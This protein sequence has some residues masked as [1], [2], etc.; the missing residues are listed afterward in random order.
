V[1]PDGE[2][3]S[4]GCQ[5]LEG[6]PLLPPGRLPACIPS[7]LELRPLLGNGTRSECSKT[8]ALGVLP[9][10]LFLARY[11]TVTIRPLISSPSRAEFAGSTL[12]EDSVL[13]SLR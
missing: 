7:V 8:R 3:Q 5:H 4:L 11:S 1:E 2:A 12:V 6:S 13:V 9:R 10:R